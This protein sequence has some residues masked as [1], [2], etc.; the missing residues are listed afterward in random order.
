MDQDKR[1]KR[2]IQIRAMLAKADSTPEPGEADV[3]RAHAEKLMNQY[4][5]EM[6]E[7]G[8]DNPSNAMD[9]ESYDMSW[10]RGEHGS[11]LWSLMLDVARHCSVK[12]VHWKYDWSTN[13]IPVVGTESDRSYFD[14]LF[15]GIM[16]EFMKGL[17]PKPDANKPMIENLVA[18][19]EAGQRWLR[20]AEQLRAIGQLTEKQFTTWDEF[21]RAEEAG[22]N[23]WPSH[24]KF[25]LMQK[26]QVHHLN[27]SGQYTSYCKK[28]DRPRLRTTP[29][30]YQRSFKLGFI[31]RMSDRLA[32]IRA[33]ARRDMS[34]QESSG[35]DLVLASNRDRANAH[36]VVLYGDP[37]K[38]R[39]GGGGRAR[40]LTIDR[41]A[42][43]SGREA[44]N[45]INL[46]NNEKVGTGRGELKR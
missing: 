22:G 33:A 31:T 42:V 5:I 30:I 14:A 16:L 11:A 25:N 10:Y 1:A 36:A 34:S 19:K 15:T 24:A 38:S 2:M 45:R 46:N 41:N 35:M 29:A 28:H 4:R 6:H 37:P 20:I 18:L 23:E 26:K 21:R 13:K 17:E 40:S 12:V 9:A 39:G 8:V 44:A 7:L 27:F 32:E 43:Q 3:F